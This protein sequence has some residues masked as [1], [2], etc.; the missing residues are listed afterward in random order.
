MQVVDLSK[1]GEKKKLIVAGVLGLVAILFLWW[2][3]FGFGSSSSSSTQRQAQVTPTRQPGKAPG[4]NQANQNSELNDL[5]D[6]LQ[7]VSFSWRTQNAPEP[8]EISCVYEPPKPVATPPKAT[9]T[10]TPT[11]TPPVLLVSISPPNVYARTG[12]LP[13]EV[14]GDKFTPDVHIYVD[15]RDL[16][17]KYRS[18]QQLSATIPATMIAMPG[19]R[20]IM[21]KTPDGRLYSGAIQLSVTSPPVPNYS[22]VGLIDTK[23]R[24]STALLQDKNNKEILN[25]QRGDVLG[26]RFRV[27]SISEKELVLGGYQ[28]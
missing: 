12:D 1:P 8:H 24:V 28:S 26:G 25:V 15:G 17:T 3:F 11:P 9:P 23:T 6:Q 22:Y 20:Q 16:P 5:T 4:N 2:I 21:V 7:E 19:V 13:L 27:T 18:A 14:A 10:P